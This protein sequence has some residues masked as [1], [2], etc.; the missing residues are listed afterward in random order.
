MELTDLVVTKGVGLNVVLQ[1]LFYTLPYFFVFTIP[2]ATLLGVLLAFLRLSSDNEITA[3]KAAGMALFQLLPPVALLAVLAWG[4]SSPLA[5]WA[6]PWG[7]HKFEKLVFQVAR[8]KT[9]LALRERLFL[10]TFVGLVVYINRL[11]GEGNLQDIFIVD[12]RDPSRVNTIVAK[13]GKLHPVVEGKVLL[14]LYDGTMHSVGDGLNSAQIATFQTYDVRIDVPEGMT[15]ARTSKHEKEMYLDELMEEMGKRT[16]GSKQYN[17]LDMELQKK[18]TLPFSCLVMALIG[19]PL[20]THTHS[21]RSWG[22]AVALVVFF[23]YYLMLSAAWSYGVTGSYPPRIGMW[24]PNLIFGLLG[25]LMFNRKLKETPIP[26]LN[27]LNK[28]PVL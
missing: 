14:R 10:D 2:M 3:F 24:V 27:S 19:L 26:F 12:E 20:G 23:S 5:I 6:M 11:P 8:A 13:H 21:G 18:F 16:P 17:L 22:V 9:D 28:L 15:A 4:L 1:L 25:I 7:N